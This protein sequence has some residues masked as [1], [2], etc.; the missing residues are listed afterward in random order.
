MGDGAIT[1]FDETTA[2]VTTAPLLAWRQTHF[3][4]TSGTGN[5]ANLADMDFDGLANLVEYALLLNPTQPNAAF[6]VNSAGGQLVLS[7]QRDP[8]RTD[9]TITI[10]AS[11][12]LAPLSWVDVARSTGGAPFTALAPEAHVTETGTGPVS[13][14]IALDTA[15]PQP[16][17]R[18]FRVKAETATP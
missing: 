10:E 5:A 2:N 4:T 16:A 15:S 13:V 14:N 8:A 12:D 11:T 9:V 7:F 3:G 1:T 17:R 6:A 18:F